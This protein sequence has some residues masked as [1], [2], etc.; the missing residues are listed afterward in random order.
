MMKKSEKKAPAKIEDG[1][2]KEYGRNYDTAFTEE[3]RKAVKGVDQMR[4]I[5][6]RK[7]I[8]FTYGEEDDE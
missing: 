7:K 2:R 8:T 5:V 1:L 6:S 3:F 4:E